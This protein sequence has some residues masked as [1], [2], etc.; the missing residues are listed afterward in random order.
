MKLDYE[1]MKKMLDVFYHSETP[2]ITI[3]DFENTG[4]DEDDDLFLFY[5]QIMEDKN[6]ITSMEGDGLGYSFGSIGG[7]WS[8]KELRLTDI[9]YDFIVA[10]EQPGV[11][12]VIEKKFKTEG[13]N[14]VISISK[15]LATNYASE[16]LKKYLN[17]P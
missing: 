2:Y 17:K 6:L 11:W 12:D 14:T 10:L 1:R 5:M 4:L 8:V 16:K 7:V 13:L 3:N 9:G 15:E